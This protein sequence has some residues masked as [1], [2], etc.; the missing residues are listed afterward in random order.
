MAYPILAPNSTWYKST[1]SRS[2]ITEINIVDFYSGGTADETWNADADNSG[3]IKCY[4]TGTV[5]TIA[6]NGSGKIAMN[7]DSS[8]L[9]GNSDEQFTSLTAINGLAMF[10]ASEVT[11]LKNAFDRCAKVTSL[12]V[13]GWN[14]SKVEDMARTL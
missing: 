6:G 13:D 3:S 9:F 14:V 8:Y 7:A 2:T 1:Q 10:D 4:R 11:T 5:L 12:D